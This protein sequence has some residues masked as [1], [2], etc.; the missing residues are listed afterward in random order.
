[1]G[2]GNIAVAKVPIPLHDFVALAGFVDVGR[3]V[4]KVHVRAALSLTAELG[5]Q[6]DTHPHIV[7]HRAGGA[8]IPQ[9]WH[10]CRGPND[11]AAGF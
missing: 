10:F 5:S 2:G 6:R 8:E 1:M 7:G 4:F 11:I 3:Q 9:F